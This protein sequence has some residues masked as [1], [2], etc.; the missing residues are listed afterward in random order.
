MPL[1]CKTLFT[2]CPATQFRSVSCL[3]DNA[4]ESS[5]VAISSTN[6]SLPIS[7]GTT[8]LTIL[9]PIIAAANAYLTPVLRRISQQAQSR[10]ATLLAPATLHI[11][12]GILTIVLA[13][14]SFEGLLPGRNLN[15]SLEGTWQQLWRNQDGRSIERIQDAFSC[16][17][18]NS[19]KHMSWPRH[20]GRTDLCSQLYHRSSSCASS[21]TSAMQRNAGLDFGVA[22]TVGIV[23]VSPRHP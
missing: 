20:D 5:Y 11:L 10:A 1:Q 23:Q 19:V 13:T 14:L 2:T 7:L 16:C 18:F 22:V 21:W 15:C 9:L 17:G 6:L 8:I 4:N 12:Q 3:V